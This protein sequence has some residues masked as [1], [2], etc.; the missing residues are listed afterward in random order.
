MAQRVVLRHELEDL[1]AE[2]RALDP[3][4]TDGMTIA[5]VPVLRERVRDLIIASRAELMRELAAAESSPAP[6]AVRSA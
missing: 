4:P 1:R 6:R 5:D 2:V 3:I